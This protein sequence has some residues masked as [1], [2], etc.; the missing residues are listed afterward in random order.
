MTPRSYDS[1]AEGDALP[2]VKRTPT[3]FGML[4]FIGASWQWS[5]QFFDPAAALSMGFERPI[6]PG[7]V[8]LAFVEQFVR[9]WLGGAGTIR[10]IQV[11]HRRPDLHD[12]EMTFGGTVTRKY[13]EDGVRFVDVEL[14]IDNPQGERSVRGSSTVAFD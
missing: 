10:R 11:S 4:K 8:K 2:P 7:T 1:I 14:W 3:H 13:Q 9:R 6:V 12:A 5:P